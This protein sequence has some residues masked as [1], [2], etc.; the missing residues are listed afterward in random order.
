MECLKSPAGALKSGGRPMVVL[1]F[2]D[3]V[4]SL[5]SGLVFGVAG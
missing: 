5:G 2:S 4:K 3:G 1:R